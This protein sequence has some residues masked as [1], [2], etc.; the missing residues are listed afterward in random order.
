MSEENTVN[1]SPF[2]TPETPKQKVERKESVEKVI[3]EHEKKSKKMPYG[4]IPIKL[5]SLGKLTAPHTLHFRN[6]SIEEALSLA[7]ATDE[8]FLKILIECLNDMCY[9][10]FDCGFLNE[11]ELIEIMLTLFSSFWGKAIDNIAYHLDPDLKPPE[12]NA[13][14]N[15]GYGLIPIANIKTT[16]IPSEFKE[17]ITIT[18]NDFKVKFILSRINFALNATKFVDK[19]FRDM[20]RKFSDVR[21]TINKNY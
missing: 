18:I 12:L 13:K 19:K 15:I 1:E 3:S 9:E 2:F 21:A 7:T 8:T 5:N 17:P 10:G 4:Y 20:D 14:E 11:N 6:Y 16:P